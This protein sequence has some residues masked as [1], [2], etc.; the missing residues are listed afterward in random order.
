MI[1]STAVTISYT[2]N[3][4]TTVFSYPYVYIDQ[5]DLIVQVITAGVISTKALGT[6]YSVT[7]TGGTNVGYNSGSNVTFVSAPAT[8]TTVI[9]TRATAITQSSVYVN[10]DSFPAATTEASLDKAILII[11]EQTLQID[12]LQANPQWYKSSQFS[13]W[14]GNSNNPNNL[15]NGNLGDQIIDVSTG[16]VWKK[17]TGNNTYTGWV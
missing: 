15:V 3:N 9:I 10:N 7:S 5:S 8:G 4:S 2:G 17:L 6:D 12:I 1:S 16:Q 11:Q 13:G 14:A